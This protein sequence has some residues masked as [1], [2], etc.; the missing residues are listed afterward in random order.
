MTIEQITVA[1]MPFIVYGTTALVKYLKPKVTGVTLLLF[2]AS[3]S[4]V[5]ALVAG[6]T[7]APDAGFLVVFSVNML[8]VVVNQFYKQW[9]SGN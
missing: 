4:T 7:V 6:I 2:T 8:T 1:L 3:T 9:K 5:L